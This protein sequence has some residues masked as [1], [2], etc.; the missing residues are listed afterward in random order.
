VKNT[1]IISGTKTDWSVS[2]PA[3]SEIDN[4]ADTCCAGISFRLL[5]FTGMTCS[6]SPFHGGYAAMQDIPI[7]TFATAVDLTSGTTVILIVNEAL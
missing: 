4:Q 3:K 2:A 1:K 6:V 7:A 5:E